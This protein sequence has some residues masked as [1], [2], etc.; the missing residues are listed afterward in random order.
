M[1]TD[2][3][4]NATLRRVPL[5]A[6][7]LLA[8]VCLILISGC[9]SNSFQV[10]NLAKSDTD[11]VSDMHIQEINALVDE[12]VVKL[13]KRNPRELAKVPGQTVGRRL[14]QMSNFP[15]ALYY[16]E[17]GG[18]GSIDAMLLAFDEYYQGDRVFALGIGLRGM[19]Y[20][21]YG[22][23]T[24]LFLLDSLDPQKLYNSARNIEIVAWRLAHRRD[25][26]GRLLLLT[27]STNGTVNLSFERLFG[28][29]IAN[30]DM[31]SG[32]IAGRANRTINVIVHSIAQAVFLPV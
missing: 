4:S 28:K 13:Y 32:I 8:S 12:L 19:L 7:L 29:M 3:R 24:E 30:Q 11:L 31:I 27:N 20:K 9:G 22:E 14:Q 10:R 18:Q 25:A 5:S 15:A 26:N 21:A 2:T 23:R 17:L 1:L 16:P 6:R